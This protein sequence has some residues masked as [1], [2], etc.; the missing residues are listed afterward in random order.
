[1]KF[2]LIDAGLHSYQKQTAREFDW[3]QT[4][5]TSK[6]KL[7]MNETLDFWTDVFG[8]V[9]P[10]QSWL[11]CIHSIMSEEKQMQCASLQ[12]IFYYFIFEWCQPGIPPDNEDKLSYF[13]IFF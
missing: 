12:K 13:H 4:E 9:R 6:S 11:T 2:V 10:K 5:T 8:N 1:M 3:K 7:N